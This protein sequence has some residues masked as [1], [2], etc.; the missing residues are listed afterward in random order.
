MVA[1]GNTREMTMKAKWIGLMAVAGVL[2]CG[3]VDAQAQKQSA[4]WFG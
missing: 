2:L 1:T 3:A 4:G